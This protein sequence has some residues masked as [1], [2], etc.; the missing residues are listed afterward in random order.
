M[1]TNGGHGQLLNLVRTVDEIKRLTRELR[2]GHNIF[3]ISP[4]RYDKTSLIIN[5]LEYLNKEGLFTFYK[6]Y[7][8][9]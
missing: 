7:H 1:D 5:V 9:C 4:R 2:E 8:R 6:E 3:L